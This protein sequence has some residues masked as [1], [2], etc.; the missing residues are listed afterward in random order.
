MAT[1]SLIYFL[2]EINI[3][4]EFDIMYLCYMLTNTFKPKYTLCIFPELFTNND[5]IIV[6]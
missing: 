2:A 3:F 4:Y 1:Y 5:N 6:L